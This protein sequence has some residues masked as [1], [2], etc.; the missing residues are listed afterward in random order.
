[1][2]VLLHAVAIQLASTI[3]STYKRTLI[4]SLTVQEVSPQK[5]IVASSKKFLMS[6]ELKTNP[7]IVTRT[8]SAHLCVV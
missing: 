2:L 5:A 1:M 7:E 6:T 8:T 3:E 4:V